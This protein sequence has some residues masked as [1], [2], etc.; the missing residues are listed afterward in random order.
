MWWC[1]CRPFGGSTGHKGEA[2]R[3]WSGNYSAT[4]SARICALRS[5]EQPGTHAAL[6]RGHL[7]G[8]CCREPCNNGSERCRTLPFGDD[9][10]IRDPSDGRVC[11]TPAARLGCDWDP[12]VPNARGRD[13]ARWL[14]GLRHVFAVAATWEGFACGCCCCPS[15]TW[16]RH[17]EALIRI[18]TA[19]RQLN[20]S[21]E[22]RPVGP[23]KDQPT[24]W[25]VPRRSIA[26]IG[27][28]FA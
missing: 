3:E 10:I 27:R 8:R 1:W 17:F 18:A 23:P 2:R 24:G 26:S 19:H 16:T 6:L 12:S 7:S 14:G 21:R 9:C 28:S 5:E 13:L 25:A 22:S 20:F 15:W 11:N 4:H